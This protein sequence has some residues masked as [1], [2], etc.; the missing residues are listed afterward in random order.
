MYL[1]I[2]HAPSVRRGG[3]KKNCYSQLDSTV[4]RNRCYSA[5]QTC[6]AYSR[7]KHVLHNVFVLH[8]G[9]L[10]PLVLH[11]LLG[12]RGALGLVALLAE[13]RHDEGPVCAREGPLSAS[14]YYDVLYGRGLV[15][16]PLCSSL[17]SHDVASHNCSNH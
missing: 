17:L 1:S 3:H 10:A 14:A 16:G 15:D 11:G 6:S 13:Q 2:L 9:H 4:G 12:R 8:R 7:S 5:P